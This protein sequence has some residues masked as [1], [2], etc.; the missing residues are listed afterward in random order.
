[1]RP[2]DLTQTSSGYFHNGIQRSRSPRHYPAYRPKVTTTLSRAGP[3]IHSRRFITPNEEVYS[4]SGRVYHQSPHRE[5]RSFVTT[6][7]RRTF[8]TTTTSGYLGE[9]IET[10]VN[11]PAPVTFNLRR[12]A[13]RSRSPRVIANS[14]RR[15]ISHHSPPPVAV[16]HHEHPLNLYQVHNTSPIV[17]VKT[18]VVE[19][20]IPVVENIMVHS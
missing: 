6:H 19:Q 5:T 4:P 15:I 9:H 16:Y 11:Q 2:L 13:S 10:V 20:P 12:E 18:T 7:P 17:E 8:T 14:S 1:M 3:V